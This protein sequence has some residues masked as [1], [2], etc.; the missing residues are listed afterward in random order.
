[1]KNKTIIPVVLGIAV[2][3]GTAYAA[4]PQSRSAAKDNPKDKAQASDNH[5]A[6]LFAIHCGRCHKPPDDLSPRVVP[7]VMA[8]MRNR[9][10]LSQKEEEEI[11]KF[12]APQ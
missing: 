2:L 11:L 8:H 7:A 1:M 3:L 9:A 6:E 12:L 10:M 5:G 4:S